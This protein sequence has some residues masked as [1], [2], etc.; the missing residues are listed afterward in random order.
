MLGVLQK[1]ALAAEVAKIVSDGE[2]IFFNSG[3]TTLHVARALKGKKHLNIV[4][5]SLAISMELGNIPTFHV[6][7]LGGIVYTYRAG[8]IRP[9]ETIF[10]WPYR[11]LQG[12]SRILHVE[13]GNEY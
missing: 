8:D 5:N 13:S 11:F 4:T 6:L 3:T 9:G 12:W 10:V 1:Q 2:T 7:L